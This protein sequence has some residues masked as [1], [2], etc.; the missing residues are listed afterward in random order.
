M[1]LLDKDGTVKKYD[2]LI[3]GVSSSTSELNC[4]TSSNPIAT[5]VSKL[6]LS[7]GN[8]S[9]GSLLTLEMS[10]YDTNSTYAVETTQENYIPPATEKYD[11]STGQNEA[12]K[13]SATSE[14]ATVNASKPVSQKGYVMTK[15]MPMSNL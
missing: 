7:S 11:N 6:H 12:E 15:K 1:N 10:D 3:N 2:C 13:G 5:T 4:N 8:S 14:D 9:D